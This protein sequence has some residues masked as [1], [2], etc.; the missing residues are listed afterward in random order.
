V[1]DSEGHVIGGTTS[2][3]LCGLICPS[4][5]SERGGERVCV[6][7]GGEEEGERERERVLGLLLGTREEPGTLTRGAPVFPRLG[8]EAARVC[9]YYCSTYY[10][11]VCNGGEDSGG[12]VL[13]ET[14]SRGLCG[15]VCTSRTSE[16][17]G[18]RVCVKEGG[19]EEGERERERALGLLLC[20]GPKHFLCFITAVPIL[21]L[22][23][24]GEGDSGGHVLR[25][26]TSRGLCGLVCPSC[27]SERGG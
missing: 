10:K 26:T 21:Q 24:W 14:T 2:R 13:R 20:H 25:E 16:R 17:G 6:K 9:V 15:L 11:A 12:H 18:E 8:I 1:G 4:R 22:F 23:A 19:G 7:E 3:G 5:T 27:T